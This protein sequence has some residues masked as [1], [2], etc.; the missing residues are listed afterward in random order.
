M[1]YI[2]HR[3]GAW[4]LV[5]L[6]G[7]QSAAAWAQPRTVRVGVYANEPKIYLNA[8]GRATGI[9]ADLLGEIAKGEGWALE[10]VPCEWQACLDALEADRI[11]LMPDVAYSAQRD[12]RFDFHQ[13]PVMHSWSQ[14]YRHPAV[15]I[16]SILDLEGKRVALL[17]GSIQTALFKELVTGFGVKPV[18]VPVPSLDEAFRLVAAGKADAAIANHFF[19]NRLSPRYRL[20]ETPIVFQPSRLFFAA[21]QDR[22]PEL[23]ATID[24]YLRDWQNDPRSMYFAIIRQ[25]GGQVPE[26]AVPR[27][28]WWGLA[29]VGGLL[30]LVM[31]LAWLLRGQV[32]ARTRTLQAANEEVSRFKAI[33]DQST[34]AAW[35]AGLDGQLVY[36]N[37]RCAALQGRK[38]QE[39]IGQRYLT[40]YAPAGQDTAEAYWRSVR[41]GGDGAPRELLQLAGDGRE[42]PMLSSGLL[43]RDAQGRPELLACTAVDISDRKQAEEKIHQL[44]FYDVLTGLPNRRLLMDHLAHAL[45]ASAR[46]GGGGAL[47]FIDLDHFKTINDTLGH[48]VGDQLLREVAARI[49]YCVRVGDTVARLGGDEF[50]VLIED[51]GE[52]A[53]VAA[54]QAEAVGRK[55]MAALSQPYRLGNSQHHSTPSIGVALFTNGQVQGDELLKQ[56]DLAM[57]QAKAAGRNSLRFFDPRMQTVVAAR[58][59]LQSDLREAMHSGQLALHIQ[60]QVD[61]AGRVVGAEAL[62]RWTHPVRGAVSPVEFIPVAEESGLMQELGLWVLQRA[63]ELLVTWADQPA[64]R[65]L[66]LAVNVSVQQFR[67]PDFVS[68]VLETLLRTG[69]VAARLK[70]EITESLLM[71]DVEDVIVKM[72]ALRAHGVSFS[73]DDFGTG[74]SSLSYLKRLPLDQLKIDASFVRDLLSDP[75]DAAIVRTIMAL[76]RSLGLQVVAE[77]VETEAQRQSLAAEGCPAYQGYYFSRPVPAAVFKA[78]AGQSLPLPTT[79]E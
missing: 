3:W 47:L 10:F 6:L 30:L 39:L 63:C 62:L 27:A 68:Q 77:G 53:E 56:A 1:S 28:F 31:L 61:T 64:L 54:G 35:I 73:L 15:S 76:A 11:D 52:V 40:L 2:H 24:R 75:N 49:S 42:L 13:V 72:E 46:H 67:H 32:V 43:L 60:P 58:A 66:S 71:E 57:Y 12:Q 45:A 33:F 7:L 78:L 8:A 4:L 22:N 19:G 79:L 25:W 20:V 55:I 36:V 16:N 70:L 69:A 5:L 29:A 44:A 50:I 37:A 65:K 9:F 34:F 14:L 17:E 26:P 38:P 21:G 59:S 18:L 51:L 48:A 74:Y 41:E 23:L